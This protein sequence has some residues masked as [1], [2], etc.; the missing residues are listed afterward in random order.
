M[1]TSVEHVNKNPFKPLISIDDLASTP[2]AGHGGSLA[3][4]ALR[5]I[6][7]ATLCT[8]ALNTEQAQYFWKGKMTS[9]SMASVYVGLFYIATM[10][11]TD[12]V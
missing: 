9:S 10:D 12:D 5:K 11:N 8:Q 3:F 4:D 6:H 7:G 1:S 2:D